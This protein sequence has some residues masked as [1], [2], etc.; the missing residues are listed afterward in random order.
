M[1]T[2]VSIHIHG[3]LRYRYVMAF[4]QRVDYIFQM[5]GRSLED[6]VDQLDVSTVDVGRNRYENRKQL[7]VD[8]ALRDLYNHEI[9]DDEVEHT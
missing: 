8:V 1:K 9:F 2:F 4:R 7:W 5:A 6:I 3:G